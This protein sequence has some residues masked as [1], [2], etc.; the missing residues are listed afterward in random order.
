MINVNMPHFIRVILLFLSFGIVASISGCSSL[1]TYSDSEQTHI[2]RHSALTEQFPN[3]PIPDGFN[4]V[5]GKSFIYISGTGKTKVGKLYFS[6]WGK[7]SGLIKFYQDKMLEKNWKPLSFIG[8][9]TTTMVFEQK[10]HI[11]TIT[12]EP[13]F[14]KTTVEINVGPK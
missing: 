7:V 3:I 11:C 14:W 9:N 12:M 4:L 1:G 5:R 6:S 10:N 13:S 2:D 8:Q